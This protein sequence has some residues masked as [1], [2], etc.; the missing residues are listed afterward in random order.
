M[1]GLALPDRYDVVLLDLDGTLSA[2]GASITAAVAASLAHVGAAPLDDAALR[3][4]IGPPL[5]DSFAVLPRFDEARVQEAV[6]HYR[7]TYD[8]LSPPLYPGALEALQRLRAAGLRLALATSKPEDLARAVVD[9]TCVAPLLDVVAGSDRP[10]GRATKADVV[11]RALDLLAHQGPTAA[12]SPVMVG[13]RSHDVLGAAAHGVPC[14][15][16]TWGYGTPD[17]LTEAGAVAL[18]VDLPHLVD[19]LVA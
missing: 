15:G 18:A 9:H 19:L 1:N 3:A 6:D 5:E 2:A 11:R 14:I 7:A 13:D 4:F 12:R 16:A 17:E 8:H 10:A